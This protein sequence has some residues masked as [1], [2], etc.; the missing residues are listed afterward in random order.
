VIGGHFVERRR[1]SRRSS[2]L[3]L[4]PPGIVQLGIVPLDANGAIVLPA[5]NPGVGGAIAVQAV[6][7][8][9]TFAP[10]GTSVALSL[11]LQ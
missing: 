11:R 3:A 2:P 6:V 9:A 5:S 4:A 7:L 1:H 8:D 10:R